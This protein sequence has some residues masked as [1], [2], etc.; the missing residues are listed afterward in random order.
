M[1]GI[2]VTGFRSNLFNALGSPRVISRMQSSQ[3]HMASCT[4]VY[5]MLQA[6]NVTPRSCDLCACKEQQQRNGVVLI[7]LT[8]HLRGPAMSA[9]RPHGCMH[10]ARDPFKTYMTFN[11]LGSA[12]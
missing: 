1:Q 8:S 12:C 6:L 2:C 10:R 11:L 4:R 3:A 7:V 9:A 5:V